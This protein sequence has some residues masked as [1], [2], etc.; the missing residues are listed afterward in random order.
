MATFNLHTVITD[1]EDVAGE[2]RK[3]VAEFHAA[4]ASI[5]HKVASSKLTG[6]AGTV[7]VTPAPIEPPAPV[8]A[9]P[10]AAPVE[11]PAAEP[12]AAEPEPEVP[13]TDAADSS[14]E[15]TGS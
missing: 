9:A 8:V 14:T 2:I 15:E 3:I 13:P 1:V 11:E 7:D 6:D 12:V 10:V 5:G 4:L